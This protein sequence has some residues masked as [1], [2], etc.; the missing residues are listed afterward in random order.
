MIPSDDMWQLGGLLFGFYLPGFLLCFAVV[1]LSYLR[2][3][4]RWP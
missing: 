3:L 4:E 2:D 1:Y